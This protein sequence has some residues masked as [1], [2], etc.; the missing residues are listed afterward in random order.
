MVQNIASK[1][2]WHLYQQ[3]ANSEKRRRFVSNMKASTAVFCTA[4]LLIAGALAQQSHPA[5]RDAQAMQSHH[6]PTEESDGS[7]GVVTGYVRDIACL[8]R[9][10]KA[11]AATTPMTQDCL[12]KCVGRGSPIG[13]LTEDGL[14][15][16][17]ISDAIPDKN[18]GTELLPYAGKYVK[19]TGKRF[20][21]GGLHAIS[22]EKIEV[23]SRPAD[24][25]IPTS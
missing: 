11:G 6:H 3:A 10:P 12:K 19:A 24:S 16:V 20:E 14:L 18:V 15:Y 4:A 25:K 22:I 9:N 8:L 17:P 21:R 2:L 7:P 13:I 23:I 1:W 5:N